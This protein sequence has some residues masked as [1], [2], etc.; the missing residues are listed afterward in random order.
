MLQ[1]LG[2]QEASN[3]LIARRGPESIS[4]QLGQMED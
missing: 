1:G 4:L 3:V 2:G